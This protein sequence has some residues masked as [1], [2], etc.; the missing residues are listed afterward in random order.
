MEQPC[1]TTR[2]MNE[3]SRSNT[4]HWTSEPIRDV[5]DAQ[6]SAII[7]AMDPRFAP[8]VHRDGTIA[9][10]TDVYQNGY[11]AEEA[12]VAYAAVMASRQERQRFA[13]YPPAAGIFHSH[14]QRRERAPW[15]QENGYSTATDHQGWVRPWSEYES[16]TIGMTSVVDMQA[17]TDRT[18]MERRRE[19]EQINPMSMSEVDESLR[20]IIGGVAGVQYPHLPANS[21]HKDPGHMWR[22]PDPEPPLASTDAAGYATCRQVVTKAVP[23]STP[24]ETIVLAVIAAVTSLSPRWAKTLTHDRQVGLGRAVLEDEDP[25]DGGPLPW[26]TPR[27]EARTAM[28]AQQWRSSV[29]AQELSV[30]QPIHQSH[31]VA[32]AGG[33]RGQA[34]PTTARSALVE[35]IRVTAGPA[36]QGAEIGV[37]QGEFGVQR[38]V[39]PYS[40]PTL[41][42][43]CR[44]RGMASCPP[45]RWLQLYGDNITVHGGT[46]EAHASP[47]SDEAEE[48][49]EEERKDQRRCSMPKRARISEK[50]D[51]IS[52]VMGRVLKSSRSFSESHAPSRPRSKPQTQDCKTNAASASGAASKATR[53][54]RWHVSGP[55]D[56]LPNAPSS[57]AGQIMTLTVVPGL[58]SGVRKKWLTK[59]R[60]LVFAG[61]FTKIDMPKGKR[62]CKLGRLVGDEVG[63]GQRAFVYMDASHGSHE[64]GD[65][66][67]TSSLVVQGQVGH[68]HAISAKQPTAGKWS[69]EV[70]TAVRYDA[71]PI[72][73]R[74]K[75]AEIDP[76][77][78]AAV[79]PQQ[80]PFACRVGQ[81]TSELTPAS[82]LTRADSNS[83]RSDYNSLITSVVGVP[84]IATRAER[85]LAEANTKS[86]GRSDQTSSGDQLADDGGHGK[87]TCAPDITRTP[88]AEGTRGSITPLY[89]GSHVQSSRR[90]FGNEPRPGYGAE[91][92]EPKRAVPRHLS[93]A[94]KRHLT[95]TASI[96]A[97][98]RPSPEELTGPTRAI[99]NSSASY[100]TPG[101]Q[102]PEIGVRSFSDLQNSCT[103]APASTARRTIETGSA[104][105]SRSPY[106]LPLSLLSFG[107]ASVPPEESATDGLAMEVV[108]A[109]TATA[110]RLETPTAAAVGSRAEVDPTHVSAVHFGRSSVPPCID[111]YDGSAGYREARTHDDTIKAIDGA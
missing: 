18:W 42:C 48:C 78:T 85:T 94:V 59:V 40:Q 82:T 9:F 104:D 86:P 64:Q 7:L 69:A 111:M 21:S 75:S 90:G 51:A 35:V 26:S 80:M 97:S 36:D 47:M 3:T 107:A 30:H 8:F 58:M 66:S 71:L 25:G 10:D 17:A 70:Q 20:D 95:D 98:L 53:S 101:V 61:T 2:K 55:G 41:S 106:P 45:S 34:E 19:R 88:G 100:R 91:Q 52:K 77:T 31:G 4:N 37:D 24:Q 12:E 62:F 60:E 29:V 103:Q 22:P 5:I 92:R 110:S 54:M 32:D 67:Y 49:A 57:P 81:T 6:L 16:H 93:A 87:E 44:E 76:Q 108:T 72:T 89:L 33:T 50:S 46:T 28:T 79:G 38:E 15:T 105:L 43:T 63:S 39:V 27:S 109:A 73:G 13:A 83:P 56:R 23:A 102:E 65:R 84:S 11:S 96:Q 1:R 14:T 74:L 68:A 99:S